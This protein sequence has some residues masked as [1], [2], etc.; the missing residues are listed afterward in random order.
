MFGTCSTCGTSRT[1]WATSGGFYG[2]QALGLYGTQPPHESF[3]EMARDYLVELR[4][5]QPAGPYLIGGFSGGGITAYE[6]AQQL[7]AAGEEVAFLALLDSAPPHPL[8]LRLS[9]R[10]AHPVAARAAPRT[11]GPARVGARQAALAAGAHPRAPP[12][13]GRAPAAHRVP[14]GRDRRR[15]PARARAL[16][17]AALSRAW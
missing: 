6:M 11:D 8:A 1:S 10:R 13:R 17:R 2:L 9:E 12:R 15:L 7:C 14:L 3:E 16:H 5:V 4:R